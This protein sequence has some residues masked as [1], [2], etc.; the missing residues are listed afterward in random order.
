[1]D[2]FTNMEMP[3]DPVRTVEAG[4][5]EYIIKRTDPF[6]FYVVTPRSGRVPEKLSGHFTSHIA[7]TKAVELYG[8]NK[9]KALDDGKRTTQ[10]PD[11]DGFARA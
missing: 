7:A 9:E 6:G 2:N 3:E 8:K 11:N 1:M 5:E 4:G 10:E